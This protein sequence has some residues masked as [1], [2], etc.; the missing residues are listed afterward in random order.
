MEVPFE[1]I[2]GRTWQVKTVF[3]IY[4]FLLY[5]LLFLL[6]TSCPKKK[7]K[8]IQRVCTRYGDNGF[9]YAGPAIVGS[10]CVT[11]HILPEQNISD[12]IRHLLWQLA[13]WES[14]QGE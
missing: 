11:D 12:H 2:W 13:L 8:G 14:L 10:L 3:S 5:I 6:A 1:K 7:M 4:Y 9:S